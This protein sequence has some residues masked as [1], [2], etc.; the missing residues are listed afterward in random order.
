MA[1]SLLSAFLMNISRAFAVPALVLF[2]T[3]LAPPVFAQTLDGSCVATPQSRLARFGADLGSVWGKIGSVA[4]R[5]EDRVESAGK[6]A[7]RGIL[8]GL[9]AA[10]DKVIDVAAESI[11]VIELT[12]IRYPVTAYESKLDDAVTR[13][14]RKDA[15]G[16]ADLGR[17][18]FRGIVD[19][20]LERTGDAGPA[21]AAGMHTLNIPTLDNSHPTEAQMKTFLDFATD[22]ANQPL[23]IHCEAGKGRTG[24]ASAVYRMAVDGFTY[25]Q[26]MAEAASHGLSL[27]N[28]VAFLKQFSADL[29]AGKI[30]GYPR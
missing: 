28:Q 16:I 27:P 22:P 17:R 15:E 1:W 21:A 14:S 26:A 25:D 18:G 3:T 10:K 29:A 5:I 20:T 23:Y 8:S 30:T 11:G 24:I 4:N 13:G 7:G 9:E 12:G 2:A 6:A 19:L